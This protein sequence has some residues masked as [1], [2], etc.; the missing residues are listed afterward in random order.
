MQQTLRCFLIRPICRRCLFCP[1][2]VLRRKCC[3]FPESGF[4]LLR[5]PS[6]RGLGYVK[7]L[8]ICILTP[9]EW[10]YRHSICTPTPFYQP[11]RELVIWCYLEIF[12][13]H[14]WSLHQ[15]WGR[16]EGEEMKS[17]EICK[18][19]VSACDSEKSTWN[20]SS[21][22]CGIGI[23][24]AIMAP[25]VHIVLGN[26]RLWLIADMFSVKTYYPLTRQMRCTDNILEAAHTQILFVSTLLVMVLYLAFN[27]WCS[28][29][30]TF[31]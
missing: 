22:V 11:P 6:T 25:L 21:F 30:N 5:T 29:I 8:H 15:A 18:S 1:H 20:W 19:D 12:E 31:V 9:I 13:I 14:S 24:R 23:S 2:R 3:C 7:H 17:L 26:L 27:L 16:L 4:V 10:M 28:C